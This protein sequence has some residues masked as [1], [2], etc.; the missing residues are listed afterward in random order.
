MVR[1]KSQAPGQSSGHKK[2]KSQK[3]KR[4]SSSASKTTTDE[5]NFTKRRYRPGTRALMEIRRYQK[6]TKLLIP[7]L[8]FSRVVKE[9]ISYIV[10]P[11]LSDFRVQFAALEAIQ[12]AAEMYLVQYFEDS[13]LCALHAKRVTLMR[14]DLQLARRIRG[15]FDSAAM[16]Y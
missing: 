7:R 1:R 6:T 16:S 9:I 2:R 4:K 5:I 10:P 8:P 14:K 11:H 15:R 12:E 13:L 3:N